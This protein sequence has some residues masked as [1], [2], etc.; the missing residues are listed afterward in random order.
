MHTLLVTGPG[1]AGRSTVAA[2]TALAAARQGHRVVLVTADQGDPPITPHG[3]LRVTRVD[4]GEEFRHELVALQERGSAVLGML[5]ARPLHTDEITELPGAEQFALLRALRR[6]AAEPGTDLVVV[7]MPPLHQAITTLALPAQLRRYLARLLPAERQ[8]ARA[9]RPVLAQLAGVPMPAQW[10][11]E[12]AARWDED[13]A[14]VQDLLE[15]PTTSVRLVAEPGPAADAALRLGGLGLALYRLPV[16]ALVANRML[17]AGSTDPWLAGLAAQQ[18][19][20]AAQWAGDESLPVLPVPHLGR[21][22][23]GPED[24]AELAPAPAPA[25]A[26]RPAWTVEDRIAEDGV[27]LWRVPLPRAEKRELGLVRR[28]DELLLTVGPYRR[29][30]PLPAAL[31][32]CTVSGA[33][34]ADDELRIRF[35]PDPGLWPRSAEKA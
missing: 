33:A 7:D 5:G 16:S 2:A 17:P 20:Y 23:H 12:A 4:S 1:G 28:G 24:L 13:L 6:A 10:L 11:Y 35:T 22:P 8:A 34:L 21:D 26:P 3:T 30:V 32:R 18:E 27:L 14:A 29:I 31:R 25:I 19:K 9:L 15:A